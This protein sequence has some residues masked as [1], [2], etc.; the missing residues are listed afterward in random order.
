MLFAAVRKSA[1]DAV[2]G[3]STGTEERGVDQSA[4]SPLSVL[5]T[6]IFEAYFY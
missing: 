6:Q 4:L 1:P 3:S 2:D 5:K